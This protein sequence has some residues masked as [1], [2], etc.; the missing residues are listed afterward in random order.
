[1]RSWAVGLA[2]ASVVAILFSI[3]LSQIL[4]G[5][6]L[7]VVLC[8]PEPLRM[9]PFRLPL[10]LLFSWTLLSAI[11]SEHFV[12]GLPQIRKFY[13]YATLLVVCTAFRS[14]RQV[15]T[16]VWLWAAVAVASSLVAFFQLATRYRQARAEGAN[17]YEYFLD[18][19]LHG[20]AG[21]WMTF[22]GELM[23]VSLLLLSAAL[24]EQRRIARVAAFS[25]LPLLWASLALGLTRSVFLVGVPAGAA[26]LLAAWRRWTVILIP[27]VI[28]FAAL[29]M[30]F[31]VRERIVSVL[32]P[33]GTDDSNSRRIILVRTGLHMI[34]DH[35]ILGVGP[36]QVGR[37]FLAYVPPDVPRP[38]PRGWYGHLHN[39]FLQFAAER[40]I[41]ALLLVLW[42]LC[43]ALWDLTREVRRRQVRT[44]LRQS[45]GD[46]SLEAG[47]EQWIFH[48]AV[49]VTL[50]VIAE[51]CFEHNLGDSE[52]L[53]MFLAVVGCGYVVKWS[54]RVPES[55]SEGLIELPHDS[56]QAL[57]HTVPV[58]QRSSEPAR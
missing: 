7:A 58:P 44:H 18:A 2:M 9:P 56:R 4:L 30:P 19:R 52:V 28:G 50:G 36:E 15:V 16:M 42:I 57:P 10:L 55:E 5:L 12:Q 47:P 1:M 26:Y 17:Y 41:P 34:A 40:G 29:V 25:C 23:I 13:V 46:V 45:L 54:A 27:A 21:H 48:G 37:D 24:W 8:A 39:T 14:A 43:R 35:P 51:G 3:A 32:Q 31:Q 11:H 53:T 33:H 6:A 22:G 20:F 49:A 38:L